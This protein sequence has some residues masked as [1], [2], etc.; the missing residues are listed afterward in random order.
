MNIFLTAGTFD[1]L[2]RMENTYPEEVMVTM[3]N[4]NGALL[5]HETN[6]KTLFKE[7][8]RYEV[9]EASGELKKEGFAVMNNIPVTEEGRPVFEH[10][11]KNSIGKVKNQSG[12]RSFRVLRPLS[13]NTYVIMTV[14][15]NELSY[16][17][18]QSSESFFG[19]HQT[20]A[21]VNNLQPK[22]FESGSYVSK[23]SIT[24]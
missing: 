14:W 23:Y 16:Q 8:R 7:P 3:V 5:L 24:E 19:A 10:Q 20:N 2:K 6:G 15:E 17:T 18:W 12:F 4:Q 9:L 21:F 11:V 22:I 1:F 13:S